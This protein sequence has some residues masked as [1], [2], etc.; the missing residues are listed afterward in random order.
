MPTRALVT[1][2]R[3]GLKGEVRGDGKNY[4][5]SFRFAGIKRRWDFGF[6]LDRLSHLYA[7]TIGPDGI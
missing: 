6:D 2:A 4:P 7:I 1:L 3:D 5:A